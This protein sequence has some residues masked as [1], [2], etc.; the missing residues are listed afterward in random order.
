MNTKTYYHIADIIQKNRTWIKVVDTERLVEMRIIQDGNLRTLYYR[1]LTL[2]SFRE[3]EN[4]QRKRMWKISEYD[5]GQGL[6]SL[7]RKD[8]TAVKRCKQNALTLSDVEYIIKIASFGIIRLELF[9][10]DTL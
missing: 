7:C 1:S 3:H 8:P 10:Y 4:I 9:D 2:Q 6:A 5:I